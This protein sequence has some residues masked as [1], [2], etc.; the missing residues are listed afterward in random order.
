MIITLCI[1]AIVV[2]WVLAS[3]IKIPPN[4]FGIVDRFGKR[5]RCNPGKDG[6][7]FQRGI[8]R[9]GLNF[10]IPLID[11]VELVSKD[12]VKED[13]KFKFTTKDKLRLEVEG[14]FQY[15]PDPDVLFSD[16][17]KDHRRNVFL[18]VSKEVIK[19]GV[20]EAVEARLG[21][22]GGQCSSEIFITSRQALGEIINAILRMN[23]PPHRN[24]LKG[25]PA[26]DPKNP[27]EPFCGLDAL[28]TF[29]DTE[30]GVEKLVEFYNAHWRQAKVIKDNEKN[31][32][33]D[34]SEVE[35]RYGIDIESFDLGNVGFTSE[36]EAAFEEKRQSEERAHA[37]D[38]V[39]ILAKELQDGLKIDG[40]TA[41]D[42]AGRILDPTI[43]KRIVS[44]QG[45][46]GVLGGIIEGLSSK[47]E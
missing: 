47:G 42:E 6:P 7:V 12:L 15:R 16:V 13:I 9:E 17:H 33:E 45:K 37:G 26:P 18:T 38:Q 8:L 21:G 27:E 30:I 36:T 32:P 46:T 39:L 44:V 22:L 5:L 4:H 28:C 20:I 25:A 3:A 14:V 34:R 41:L 10:I 24:H 40:Q 29:D 11:S 1:I 43:K 31:L 2:V 23:K 35:R 19:S